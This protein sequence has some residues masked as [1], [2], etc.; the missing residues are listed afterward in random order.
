MCVSV[1]VLET[2]L[3]LPRAR[4]PQPLRV[5]SLSAV[6]ASLAEPTTTSQA[7]VVVAK[8]S[9]VQVLFPSLLQ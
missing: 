2:E 1:R 3:V 9:V 8:Q 5:V 6:R 7:A 4:V